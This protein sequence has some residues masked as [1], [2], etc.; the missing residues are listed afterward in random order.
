MDNMLN[1]VWGIAFLFCLLMI[2]VQLIRVCY[3]VLTG[4]G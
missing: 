4:K 3:W 1:N 2:V